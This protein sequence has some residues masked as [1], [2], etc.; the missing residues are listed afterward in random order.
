M[1]QDTSAPAR[2]QA[3][4]SAENSHV[5]HPSS[6]TF[7]DRPPGRKDT[8][9]HASG[10]TKGAANGQDAPESVAERCL[11]V[12][13]QALRLNLSSAVVAEDGSK[14]P[15]VGKWKQYQTNAAS[16]TTVRR[17]F[18]S[19]RTGV[20][21]FTGYG[22]LECLEF[23]D[24]EIFDRFVEAASVF[25]LGELVDRV[26]HGYSE[27][28]PGGG[29][30]WLY[31]C[32]ELDGNT[33]LA[34][35]PRP[36]EKNPEGR[37]PLIETRGN[38]GWIVIAP[39]NGKV[40]PSGGAYKL[41]S[42]GLESIAT[43]TPDEREALFALARSFDEIPEE[44]PPDAV[45]DLRET[46][47]RARKGGTPAPGGGFNDGGIR[48]G[49]DFNARAKLADVI[50][51]L[52]WV[53]V[54]VSGGV[55]YWRRPGKEQGW[56]ATWGKTKGFR[57][58][59]SSSSLEAKS[60]SLLYVY[61]KL[62][63]GGEWNKCIKEL[64]KQGY[65]TWIDD[66]GQEHP[67]PRPKG[68]KVVP[69]VGGNKPPSAN[70]GGRNG[71]IVAAAPAEDDRPTILISH[72]EHLNT[73]AAV[74]A[75]RV[76]PKLFQRGRALVTILRDCKPKPK[77]DR[78]KRPEG[79]LHI[80]V[81][82]APQI[83]R[84]MSVHARWFKTKKTRDGDFEIVPA[85][86]PSAIVDQVATLGEWPDIRPLEGITEVPTIR[87]DGSLIES[88]GY[89]EATGLWYSPNEEFPRIP[90]RPT[91]DDAKSAVEELY[92]LV[93]DFPFAKPEYKA[94]WLAA[95]LTPLVR[96]A[97]DGPTPLFLF[98]A[99]TPGSGKTKL[100]D[101]VAIVAT[102]RVMARG[103]YP[104]HNE[105]MQKTILSIAIEGDRAVLFDNVDSGAAIG[106]AALDRALTARTIKG[107]ILG[108]SQMTPELPFDAVLFATGNNLGL[109]GDALRR[110]VPCRLESQEERPETRKDF[111][112]GKDCV[113]GCRGDL[114]AHAKKVRGRLVR[115]ALTIVRAYIVAGRPDRGLVP[116][117]YPAWCGV[118][119][120]AVHWATDTDPCG[121]RTEL[122]ANDEETNSLRALIAAWKALCESKGRASLSAAEVVE[123][124]EQ[125]RDHHS[126]LRSIVSGWTRDGKPSSR[127]I[128]NRLNKVRGRNIGG[129]CL[130]CGFTDGIRQ[131]FV[132]SSSTKDTDGFSA[133]SASSAS[134]NPSTGEFGR[135]TVSANTRDKGSSRGTRGTR[136]TDQ[137]PRRSVEV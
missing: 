90:D 119:R 64:V 97:I 133:S 124:L 17:W 105:E 118:V 22:N 127:S 36:T 134:I 115:A 129:S 2:G 43:I 69:A 56:S 121:G 62:Y 117:D 12:A 41:L 76:E 83:R 40:H 49:D 77:G 112:I 128:G 107:R 131:W 20:G 48:P 33:K 26:R 8:S 66:Q 110:I 75:L 19:G 53:R 1:R 44:L 51:P 16:E 27:S 135:T 94:T 63:H 122:A 114:L 58:F 52:G 30:H 82:P 106:G 126:D 89:D 28:S 14:L 120:D 5:A 96:W 80:S 39:S 55:E 81:L 15:D 35:R 101:L 95:L 86:P 42:G 111:R 103:D 132:K 6:L 4:Q 109:K 100:C 78:L 46:P 31:R 47:A 54:H 59:T 32:E 23:D 91:L 85:P 70:G 99:N 88:P 37:K 57:V 125:D 7:A 50:G 24:L 3:G 79:E 104:D 60:H 18:Q 136:G 10:A 67:N 102:G 130:D 29:I 45:P 93:E 61:C 108:K 65:G 68:Q 84:L 71:A 13:L 87:P 34:E 116:M 98:D 25:G 72:E 73:A 74:L 137:S 9:T 11:A 113:C 21:L 123:F 92:A 38:G